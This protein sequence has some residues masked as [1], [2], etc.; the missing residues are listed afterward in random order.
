MLFL[1]DTPQCVAKPVPSVAVRSETRKAAS[2]SWWGVGRVSGCRI[3]FGK[4]FG[5]EFG[6]GSSVIFTWIVGVRYDAR[7][8][9]KLIEV[10]SIPE[11]TVVRQALGNSI[12]RG[13]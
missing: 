8:E 3:M 11:P 13:G 6:K 7:C 10:P 9:K 12:R 4:E 5:K 2:E 1:E